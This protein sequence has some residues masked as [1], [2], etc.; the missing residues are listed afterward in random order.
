MAH[1]LPPIFTGKKVTYEHFPDP[2]C[3]FVYRNWNTLPASVLAE[4]VGATEE[5][6]NDLAAEMGLPVPATVDVDWRT[7]GYI[8]L[9]RANWHLLTYEQYCTM[10]GWDMEKLAFIIKEDDFL[11]VKLGNQKPDVEP[12]LWHELTKEQHEALVPIKKATEEFLAAVGP[13]TAKPFSFEPLFSAVKTADIMDTT[14][15]PRLKDRI[16]YSYCALYGDT[17]TNEVEYSFPDSLLKAYQAVGVNGIWC[18]AILY[19]LVPF[20]FDESLS[21]GWQERLA[22]LRKL[23]DRMAKYGI[24]LFLYLNEP[25]WMPIEFFNKYPHLKGATFSMGPN[26]TG[27]QG[28]HL[29]TSTPEIQKYLYDS[30]ALLAR[31]APNLG[32]FF[33]ITGTENHSNCYSH[34]KNGETN[35]PRCQKR[36]RADVLAEVN[37]LLYKGAK[38]TNPNIRMLSWTWAWNE[39][40]HDAIRKL[41]DGV[42]VLTISERFIEKKVGPFTYPI[43][44]Y[45]MSVVGP[46]ENAKSDWK[47]AREC[48]LGAAAKCQFNNTWEC[49]FVPFLPVYELIYKHVQGLC[50]EGIDSALLDWTLGGYPSP[51]FAMLY[52]LFYKTEKMPTLRELYESVFTKEAADVVEKA[53][54]LFSSAFEEF[55]FS[56]GVAYQ[57]PQNVGT[58]NLLYPT[59]TGFGATMTGIPYDDTHGWTSVFSEEVVQEQFRLVSEGWAEGLDVLRAIT[60]EQIAS[61]HALSMLMDCAEAAYCHFRSSYLQFRFTRVRDE[62]EEGDLVA[63]AKEEEA[64]VLRLSKVQARNPTIGFESTNHYFYSRAALMEKYVNCKYVQS[65]FGKN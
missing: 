11:D 23:T 64:L 22:G 54:A 65:R 42:D 58:S 25:R 37:E 24:R 19:T 27:T 35:C 59:P 34:S 43:R 8:T 61:S 53:C 5:Q 2:L 38:S 51:T 41:P 28:G 18:Q 36:P 7:Y 16:V 32:G 15:E 3:T 6:I 60:P 4:T 45:C 48:G 17:F 63:I 14:A 9:I 13:Q 46:G 31:E 10:L 30:A 12:L 26:G 57:A 49:S 56:V 40:T 1:A 21:K 62:K 50:A 20:P 55:P 39:D 33:T 47:V 52:P 29:C 44:D